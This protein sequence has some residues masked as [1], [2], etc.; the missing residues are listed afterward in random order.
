MSKTKNRDHS[1]VKLLKER[2][3]DLEKEQRKLLKQLS[4]YKK[5]DHMNDREPE[6]QE[7]KETKRDDRIDCFDCG[8][9]KYDVF[10]IMGKVYGTCTICGERKKLNE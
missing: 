6:S 9:G 2:V 7:E 1:E 10:E 3:R 8:K 5:R 4:Y